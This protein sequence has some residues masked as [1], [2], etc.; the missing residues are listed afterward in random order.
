MID[1]LR[2]RGVDRGFVVSGEDGMDEISTV[3]PTRIHRLI[4]GEITEAEFTPEDFGVA[5]VT[6]GQLA[7]GDAS[8]NIEILR[9]VLDGDSGPHRDAVIVNA[10]PAIVLADLAPGF[11]EAVDVAAESIDSG[12]AR[13]SLDESLRLNQQQA[14]SPL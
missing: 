14:E 2:Q 4:D 5:R 7:G 3:A 13:R 8:R 6:V 10:A 1:V 11:T 9:S 12:R